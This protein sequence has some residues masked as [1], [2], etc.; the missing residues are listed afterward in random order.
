MSK[1]NVSVTE[2]GPDE[3]YVHFGSAEDPPMMTVRVVVDPGWVTYVTGGDEGYKDV[4]M[5]GASG[6]W[7]KR[8]AWD[9]ERGFLVTD[10]ETYIPPHVIKEVIRKWKAG[11]QIPEGFYAF[12][13]ALAGKAWIEGMKVN[14]ASWYEDGDADD[15]DN[16]IQ[17]ALF[18]EVAYG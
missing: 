18:G 10:E 3:A 1:K 12:D 6:F 8:L 7:A 13:K 9:K 17:R 15:Y 11:E 14:G 4:F 16:A 2:Y 5:Y